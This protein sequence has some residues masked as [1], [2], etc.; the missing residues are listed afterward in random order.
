MITTLLAI[1][2]IVAL[3]VLVYW[4][5]FFYGLII[6]DI[7]WHQFIRT[8]GFDCTF[9]QN[10]I[11]FIRQR[12]YGG[13]TFGLIIKK[14]VID[15]KE[16]DFLDFK[17]DHIFQ[18]SLHTVI[19]TLI[20]F[21]F[22]ANLISFCA[23]ILY[24]INP[25]N[26]QT[27]IWLNGRR[28]AV[29]I[30]LVL[31]M[32]VSKPVGFL[33]Y[34]L[35]P[36]FQVTAIFA[37]I[38]YAS[39]SPWFLVFIPIVALVG[40]KEINEKIQLR[41][42]A[43]ATKDHKRFTP[44]RLIVIVKSFGFNF[45]HAIFPGLAKMHY[46]SLYWWGRTK[47]GNKDAY[48]FNIEFF[49]GVLALVLIGAGC[50]YFKGNLLVFWVF[51][52]VSALQ[53][54]CIIPAVQYNADRYM[55][56]PNVFLMFFI[57]HLSFKFAGQYGFVLPLCLGLYYLVNLFQSMRQYRSMADFFDYHIFH[58]PELPNTRMEEVKALL[59]QNDLLA[60]M[61]AMTL[62]REGLT[63]HRVADYNTLRFAAEVTRIF[64]NF[65]EAVTLS[66]MALENHYVDQEE[67]A[68]RDHDGFCARIS[69][70]LNRMNKPAEPVSRQVR[71][72]QER[73]REKVGV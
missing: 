68:K 16:V 56:L 66:K 11:K 43:V 3:N 32:L 18:T 22:G 30:I 45:F 9:L 42:S 44:Q 13:G 60:N 12:L 14:K 48:A 61:R 27:S 28:Y 72:A 40:L 71:R 38:L 20:Y 4:R 10:P 34:F 7:R 55:G 62:V 50:A 54:C 64:G 19:C 39:I 37:P 33:L 25:A 21:A 35:T 26:T 67:I 51:M 73:Q 63:R 6:D 49:K 17:I 29:N 24:A 69:N 53:W 52:F 65:D 59:S 41:Y 47:D 57:S 23:A 46:P 5:T 70:D 58:N 1:T 15:G 8:G 2:V 36:M 31:L